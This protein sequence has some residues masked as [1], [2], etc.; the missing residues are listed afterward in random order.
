M[1]AARRAVEV[2]PREPSPERATVLATL[3]QLKMLDGIF[4]EAQRLARDAIKVARAC[5]PIARSQ[6]VHAMTTL[7][8]AL[9]WGKNPLEAVELLREA[10]TAARELN[11][12]DALFRIRANLTTVLDLLSRRAEAVEVAYEG[13]R[14]RG[15]P[16][17]R[18]STAT[19]W[20]ATWPTRSSCS[21]AGPR[22][23]PSPNAR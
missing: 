9:A 10:E 1:L 19:S 3:A 22:H 15:A 18:P 8:V 16:A 4:S 17:S 20:R 13:S 2:V 7:A 21:A 14:T 11:D 23:V 5:D 6:E 12:P